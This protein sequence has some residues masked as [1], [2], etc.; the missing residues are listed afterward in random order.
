[1]LIG[2]NIHQSNFTILPRLNNCL[3]LLSTSSLN[4]RFVLQTLINRL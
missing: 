2:E 4:P 3:H 1:M